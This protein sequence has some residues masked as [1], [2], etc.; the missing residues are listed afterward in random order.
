MDY[1]NTFLTRILNEFEFKTEFDRIIKILEQNQI[2]EVEILFGW[3]WGNEYKDWV[4]FRTKV[5]DIV[6]E[7][8]KPQ[9]QKLGQLGNDD[10]FITIPE[11]EIEFLFCH[12]L[13]VHLS[14]NSDNKIVSSVI[15]SW[16]SEQIIH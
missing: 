14:F 8:D 15:D 1:T 2:D 16:V 4:P 12:E 6:S 10:I 9:Q 3:A 7:I 5:I 13:D 11:L